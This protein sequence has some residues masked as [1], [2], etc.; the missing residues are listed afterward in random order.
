M[1]HRGSSLALLVA[2][3]T[4]TGCAHREIPTPS[5]DTARLPAAPAAVERVVGEDAG[6]GEASPAAAREPAMDPHG[7]PIDPRVSVHV[8]PHAAAPVLA[9]LFPRHLSDLGRCP[10]PFFQPTTWPEVDQLQAM[11]FAAGRFVPVVEERVDATFTEPGA[12][13]SLFV[14][15][16]HDC[17]QSDFEGRVYAIFPTD[18]L[19][20]PSEPVLRWVEHQFP[21]DAGTFVAV[22]Q[23][24]GRSARLVEV[25]GD[26]QTRLVELNRDFARGAPF[27]VSA[28]AF[29][30]DG[31]SVAEPW[32][33]APP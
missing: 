25:F 13:E 18:A 27:G 20:R 28:H 10:R 14:I 29:A 9:R 23:E 21:G 33:D 26:H 31:G 4:V 11:D 22:R 17:Q 24:A 19:D 7:D 16:I 1:S 30:L 32:R 12:R 5:T 6:V 8:D 2:L 3:G 15:R